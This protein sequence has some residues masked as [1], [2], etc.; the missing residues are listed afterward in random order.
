MKTT[1]YLCT[2]TNGVIIHD[3]YSVAMYCEKYL[4]DF[5][6][7]PYKTFEEAEA[8]GMKHLR[9][10]TPSDIP[11]PSGLVNKK[12][13]TVSALRARVTPRV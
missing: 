1:Y 9:A 7:T 12:I 11:L 4:R 3:V 2:G 13:C 10:I 8:A 6:C 5:K